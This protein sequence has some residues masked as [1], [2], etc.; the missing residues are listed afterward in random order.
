VPKQTSNERE[1]VEGVRRYTRRALGAAGVAVVVATLLF[2]LW[3]T[4]EVLLLIFGGVLVGVLLAAARDWLVKHSRLSRGWAL[5]VTIM[6][7]LAI[8]GGFAWMFASQ[9]AQQIDQL[10][11]E[12]PQSLE[13]LTR[14]LTRYEW[15]RWLIS[16]VPRQIEQRA[17]DGGALSTATSVAS[18]AFR[19]FGQFVV[20]LVIGCYLAARPRLYVD[21]IVRLVPIT[22]RPR[23]REVLF[24]IGDTLRWWLLG[25][26]ASMIAVGV[27]TTIG[28]ALIG[29][30]LAL[31][32]GLIAGLMDF[33]PNIGPII[34]AVPAVLLGVTQGPTQGLSV[35]LLF[36]AI[37]T[38]EGYVITPL[39]EQRTVELPPA[40]T[41]AAQVFA[42]VL[43]GGIGLVL[44]SP[45]VATIVVLVRKLYIE[46]ALGDVD[47]EESVR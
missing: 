45:L 16:Q 2:V 36:V 43:L 13:A 38:L 12:L 3:H 4:R 8:I 44:A 47:A 25:R 6:L 24:V 21:G 27:A 17:G 30:P 11:R 33:V 34:A 1:T 10:V 46:D 14:G 20:A 42:G 15:G 29:T 39:V 37:Q 40:L 7:V 5:G 26:I 35:A 28:L 18:G 9:V 31:T 32:L 22:K 19:A 41:I 23:V